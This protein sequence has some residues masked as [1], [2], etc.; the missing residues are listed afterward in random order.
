MFFLVIVVVEAFTMLVAHNV[1]RHML[2][3][4][5]DRSKWLLVVIIAGGI[6]CISVPIRIWNSVR[7]ELQLEEQRRLLGEARL[8][9]LTHQINPHFLF[10][11]LNSI[12]SL[13]R[14]DPE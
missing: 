10:N 6:A 12:S 8:E 2:D 11:T 1:P 5:H 9:A 14:T 13:V 4:L 3:A 7:N